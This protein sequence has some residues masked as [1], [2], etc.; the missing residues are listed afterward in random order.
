[1]DAKQR[2]VLSGSIIKTHKEEYY[3]YESYKP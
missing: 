2:V 3:E 1:M